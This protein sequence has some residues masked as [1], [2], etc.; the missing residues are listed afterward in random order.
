MK[1]IVIKIEGQIEDD[2]SISE[3]E[4]AIYDNLPVDFELV[5]V[6]ERQEQ[7]YESKDC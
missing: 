1:A 5:A 6:E 4:N 2:V 3:V 7:K